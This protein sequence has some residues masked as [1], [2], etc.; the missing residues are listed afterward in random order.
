MVKFLERK[1]ENVELVFIAHDTEATE[2]EEDNFFKI[3]QGGGTMVSSAFRL[4]KTVIEDR[5]PTET[6]NNYVFAF[7]DGDNWP[8]DNDKCVQSVKDIMPLCQAVGYGEVNINDSFYN[9][10]GKSSVWS[11]LAQ[12]FERD[13]ELSENERFIVATIEKREDIYEGLKKFLRGVDEVK[14]K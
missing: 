12:I 11:N 10:S 8:E 9:W 5:F 2:V 4:A 13:S 7:S 3:S 1:H 14:T 6:W